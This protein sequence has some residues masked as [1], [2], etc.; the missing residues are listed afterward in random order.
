MVTSGPVHSRSPRVLYCSLT[1]CNQACCLRRA[2]T[3]TWPDYIRRHGSGPGWDH[4]CQQVVFMTPS[5]GNI[6][7]ITG[8]LCGEFTGHQWI[9]LT[10]ASDTELWF[11]SFIWALTN[12]WVNNRNVDDLRLR[13][14]HYDATVI[15]ASYYLTMY[16]N[17]SQHIKHFG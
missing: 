11:F 4:C 12:G 6:F 8:P 16:W 1:W 17:T 15:L 3:D 14:A 10:K 2:F 5:N 9:P 13:H 7:R